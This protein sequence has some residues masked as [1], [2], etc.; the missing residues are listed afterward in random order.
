MNLYC[1][2]EITYDTAA[3]WNSQDDNIVSMSS[4]GGE[5]FGHIVNKSTT[6]EAKYRGLTDNSTVNVI[7]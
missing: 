3:V 5:A 1:E 4:K 7:P 2:R 6:I